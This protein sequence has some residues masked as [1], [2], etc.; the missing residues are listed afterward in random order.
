MSEER[1]HPKPEEFE[2]T[3]RILV[4]MASRKRFLTDQDREDF[5]QDVMLSAFRSYDAD[6]EDGLSFKNLA[7][8]PAFRRAYQSY[9][10]R[11]YR[12]PLLRS[13]PRE[14]CQPEEHS[15]ESTLH[16]NPEGRAHM[17]A[18]IAGEPKTGEWQELPSRDEEPPTPRQMRCA[19]VEVDELCDENTEN[20]TDMLLMQVLL[21][22]IEH[23]EAPLHQLMVLFLYGM[24]RDEVAHTIGK[25]LSWAK[26]YTLKALHLLIKRLKARGVIVETFELEQLLN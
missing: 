9:W 24:T 10:R 13:L 18:G 2:R 22:E 20:P 26:K 12:S 7:C 4:G 11:F 8:G 15:R 16:G 6:R 5:V 23:L 17:A 1:T 21:E 3:Y 14:P 25:S 19:S